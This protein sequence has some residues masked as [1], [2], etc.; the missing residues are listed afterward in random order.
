MNAP[1]A[2][3]PHLLPEVA[4]VAML[5][6]DERC[7]YIDTDRWLPYQRAN[8]IINK[9]EDLL[10][11][12]RINRPPSI[13]L[14][15][16]S[17][18]GKSHILDRF[19]VL[20]PGIPNMNGPN[21][22]APVMQIETPPTASANDLY[23]IILYMLNQPR[24]SGGG[25]DSRREA[26][27]NILRIVETKV[28]MLDEIN[29]L[30][31]GTV[32]RQ[33]EFL[34][35]LKHLSNELR[36]SV[37][38]AGTPE[39]LQL[40]NLSDQIGNRFEEVMLPIWSANSDLRTL[41]ANFEQVIPLRQPSKLSGKSVALLLHSFGIETIGAV[42]LFLAKS[43]KEAIR[44]GTECITLEILKSCAPQTKEQRRMDRKYL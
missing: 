43:A 23:D 33:R 1:A 14:V 34:F 19:S 30:L 41:L 4:E 20:H 8:E 12:P 9:L 13:M 22:L 31:S 17:G 35:A 7:T 29:H 39:S 37:V 18:N 3:F 15:G 42:S 26:T 36:M 24:P 27:K 6:D 40:L 28:L 16:R 44:S 32:N 38:I 25:R 21:I 10:S 2:L 5:G 11:R